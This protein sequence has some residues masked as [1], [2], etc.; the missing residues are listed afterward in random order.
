MWTPDQP[1]VRAEEQTRNPALPAAVLHP[2]NAVPACQ[3]PLPSDG[4]ESR[5]HASAAAPPIA[6]FLESHLSAF[7]FRKTKPLTRSVTL[8]S[9]KGLNDRGLE[10]K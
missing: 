7:S 9:S 4:T 10:H 2:A 5:A 3:C 1:S 8:G 6:L